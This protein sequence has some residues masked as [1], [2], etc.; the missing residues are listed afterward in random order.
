MFPAFSK[1]D[2]TIQ[3]SPLKAALKFMAG[4]HVDAGEGEGLVIIGVC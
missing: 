3:K 4:S 1:P 2:L